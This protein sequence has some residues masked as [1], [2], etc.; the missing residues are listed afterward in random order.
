MSIKL[1]K[2][3]ISG[4]YVH[5]SKNDYIRITYFNTAN[6]KCNGKKLL[7]FVLFVRT[8]LT[9]EYYLRVIVSL[10]GY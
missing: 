6:S 9:E 4:M 8:V 10:C 7:D 3:V 2:L 1:G 5:S